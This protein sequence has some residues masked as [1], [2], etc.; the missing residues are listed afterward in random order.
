VNVDYTDLL[1]IRELTENLTTA[2]RTSSG[3]EVSDTFAKDMDDLL[4][5]SV[6]EYL[7]Q[8]GLAGVET[9]TYDD[10]LC[11]IQ[12]VEERGLFRIRG[13]VNRLADLLNVSRASIYNYRAS[14]K[15]ERPTTDNE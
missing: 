3:I 15:D 1:H 4:D 10:K 12:T 11:L 6:A 2:S 7:R 5:L 8:K 9:L 14:L 13:A